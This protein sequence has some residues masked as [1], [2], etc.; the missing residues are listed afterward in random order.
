MSQCL[1]LL[2]ILYKSLLWQIIYLYCDVTAEIQSNALDVYS[3]SAGLESQLKHWHSIPGVFCG[4][5]RCRQILGYY[6][7]QA[8]ATSFQI[9]SSSSLIN[10]SIIQCY[11]F[12]ILTA[13]LN[14]QPTNYPW[15]RC[16][17]GTRFLFLYTSNV[18]SGIIDGKIW[19]NVH[20]LPSC[21]S[22]VTV[23]LSSFVLPLSTY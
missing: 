6:V 20:L 4:F 19:M 15:S 5:L 12:S 7:N 16:G 17:I 2:S 22:G 9:L 13:S 14:N 21:L 1:P 8:M 10:H 11:T 23:T 18:K 3:G